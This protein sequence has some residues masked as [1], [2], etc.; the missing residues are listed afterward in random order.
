MTRMAVR[1]ELEDLNMRPDPEPLLTEMIHAV[2][3]FLFL[4]ITQ[5]NTR[6]LWIRSMIYNMFS[7]LFN[8][9]TPKIHVILQKSYFFLYIFSCIMN[10]AFTKFYFFYFFMYI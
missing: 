7:T 5:N 1:F 2:S 3:F 9:C 10:D 8:T 4:N 6:L